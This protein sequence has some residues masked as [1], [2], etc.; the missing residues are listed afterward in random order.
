MNATTAKPKKIFFYAAIA[1]VVLV[2]VLGIIQ[3]NIATDSSNWRSLTNILMIFISIVSVSGICFSIIS[4]LKN[5]RMVFRFLDILFVVYLLF[6][7]GSA[8]FTIMTG[9]IGFLG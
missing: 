8:I 1:S 7:L 4:I 2:L 6:V 3:S 9:G 5:K